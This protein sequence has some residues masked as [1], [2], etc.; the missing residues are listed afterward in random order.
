M[1]DKLRTFEEQIRE[2]FPEL[3]EDIHTVYKKIIDDE[4]ERLEEAVSEAHRKNIRDA[5]SHYKECTSE[6]DFDDKVRRLADKRSEGR[7]EFSTMN[8]L[9]CILSLVSTVI[10]MIIRAFKGK[11]D[12]FLP[13]DLDQWLDVISCV[14]IF[15]M[16][17]VLVKISD[18]NKPIAAKYIQKLS[19]FYGV[20][21][22]VVLMPFNILLIADSDGNHKIIIIVAL[23]IYLVCSSIYMC[24]PS[25][26]YGCKPVAFI[27]SKYTKQKT[28]ILMDISCICLL[29]A[30]IIAVLDMTCLHYE[31]YYANKDL[32]VTM[33]LLLALWYILQPSVCA[34]NIIQACR[35]RFRA[36]LVALVIIVAE[37]I[38]FL[39]ISGYGDGFASNVILF[40]KN[41]CCIGKALSIVGVLVLLI[42]SMWASYDIVTSY[43]N[44]LDEWMR[45]H[46]HT[47]FTLGSVRLQIL[48]SALATVS[49]IMMG[50]IVFRIFYIVMN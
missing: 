26:I 22:V 24:K 32:C 7:R 12:G 33:S 15:T 39:R 44:F 29:T 40:W 20:A 47:K 34:E 21:S 27:K 30:F 17:Q 28:R 41:S 38:N 19:S 16:W 36:F 13:F 50:V 45:T 43:I 46:N 5:L 18:L 14:L 3:K 37:M 42:Q 6:P 2:V 4:D 1:A 35:I 31:S 9:L 11:I 48:A 25:V 49:Y 8:N 10:C 23:V